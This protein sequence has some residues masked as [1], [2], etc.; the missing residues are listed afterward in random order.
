MPSIKRVV[1]TSSINAITSW[2]DIALVESDKIFTG[3]Y[4]INHI[5]VL[6]SHEHADK[7]TTA[8]V[9]GP[10]S[11][12]FEA[13]YASKVFAR[14]ATDDFVATNHPNF[15]VINIM[16]SFI[17]GKNELAT[18]ETIEKGTNKFALSPLRGYINP[19]VPGTTVYLNDVSK[20]HV[21]ALDPKVLTQVS[22]F[23]DHFL[24]SS[25]GVRGTTFNDSIEIYKKYF[26]GKV[27]EKLFPLTGNQQRKGFKLDSERTE[28]VFGVK[29]QGY[30]TQVKSVVE[31]YIR[32]ADSA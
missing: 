25:G 20:I 19:P 15:D 5:K 11:N 26:N 16:P 10:Y 28:K 2:E 32:L 6:I 1:I 12:F 24:V 22:P 4:P 9:P 23:Y 17:I 27:S 14:Q 7:D 8:A 29:L 30:E 31:H 13:Y 18:L 21:Q 3:I